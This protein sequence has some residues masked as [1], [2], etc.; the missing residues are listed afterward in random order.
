MGI[1]CRMCLVRESTH[2]YDGDGYVLCAFEKPYRFWFL[3]WVISVKIEPN[4]TF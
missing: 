2:D 4:G 1:D 3:V